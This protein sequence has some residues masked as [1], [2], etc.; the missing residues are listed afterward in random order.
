MTEV[1]DA[2]DIPKDERNQVLFHALQL[3]GSG[4]STTSRKERTT[5][6][7]PSLIL[8]PYFTAL[9]PN[10]NDDLDAYACEYLQHERLISPTEYPFLIGRKSPHPESKKWYARL[11]IPIY[12]DNDLIFYFGRDLS[13]TRVKKY[14]SPDVPRDNVLYGFNHMFEDIPEPLYVA[15]GWFD[16]YRL[17]GVAVFGNRMTAGQIAWLNRTP[18]QKVV[19]P[20]RFGD[21]HLLAEQAIELGWGVSTPDIGEC[22]DVNEAMVK[23]GEVFTRLSIKKHTYTDFEALVRTQTYCKNE[24]RTGKTT[25]QPPH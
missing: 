22:K 5:I 23:Y 24:P 14:M 15:E 12:K 18:R 17:G 4:T 16:V 19:I 7:P 10:S 25:H 8:P 9:D 3:Q 13:G 11:I 2:F 20:D 6:D 21:G 1:L